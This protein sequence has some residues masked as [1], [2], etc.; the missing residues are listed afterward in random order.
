MD[1]PKAGSAN[2]F[3]FV[4]QVSTT[5]SLRSLGRDS[6]ESCEVDPSSVKESE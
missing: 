3:A 2:V 1:D 5:L 6:G 4:G